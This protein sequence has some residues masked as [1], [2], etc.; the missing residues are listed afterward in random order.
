MGAKNKIA[1][2]NYKN[3]TMYSKTN[4]MIIIKKFKCLNENL[5]E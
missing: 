2:I 1:L 3:T 5:I 4:D